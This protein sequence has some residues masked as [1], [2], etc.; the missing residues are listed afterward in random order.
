MKL[1]PDTPAMTPALYMTPHAVQRP[2]R[3]CLLLHTP[4]FLAHAECHHPASS[5]SDLQLITPLPT[6]PVLTTPTQLTQLDFLFW[7]LISFFR[8]LGGGVSLN[9]LKKFTDPMQFLKSL[10]PL[11]QVTALLSE[12]RWGAMLLCCHRTLVLM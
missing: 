1:D 6:S 3:P 4:T 8:R 11:V 12:E 10:T 2:A 9:P 5:H 7:Y